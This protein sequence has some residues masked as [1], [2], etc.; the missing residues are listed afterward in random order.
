VEPVHR[1]LVVQYWL[2]RPGKKNWVEIGLSTNKPKDGKISWRGPPVSSLTTRWFRDGK[3][4]KDVAFGFDY[5]DLSIEKILRQTISLHI[6]SILKTTR[7]AVPPRLKMHTSLSKTEPSECFLQVSLGRPD[8]KTT[9]SVEPISGRY[10]LRPSTRVSAQAERAINQFGATTPGTAITQLLTQTMHD[11]IKRCA[12]LLGWRA[13]PRN[14]FRTDVVKQATRMDVLHLVILRPTGWSTKWVLAAVIDASGESWWC[15]ELGGQG[16]VIEHAERIVMEK[17]GSVMEI[18][19]ETLASLGR[20]AIQQLGY[21]VSKKELRKRGIQC[22]LRTDLSTADPSGISSPTVRSV[23]SVAL[24]GWSLEVRTLDLLRSKAGESQWLDPC[25]RVVSQGFGS[26]YQGVS[27][28]AYGMM[29]KSVATDMQRLMSASAQS[30]FVF[31]EDGKFAIHLTTPFGEPIADELTARLRDVDR[32]RSFATILQKRK[33]RLMKSSLQC[34][35]FQYGEK[36]TATVDFEREDE[37]KVSFPPENPHNRIIRL[38]TELVNSH[39]PFNPSRPEESGLDRFCEALVLTRPLLST[40]EELEKATPG[41]LH[42][43]AVFIRHMHS[44][45]VTYANPLCSFDIQLRAR[46]DKRLWHIEDNDKK[47]GDLQPERE[48]KANLERPESLKSALS[49]LFRRPAGPEH[50]WFGVRSGIVAEVDGITNALR[51]LHQAVTSCAS[52]GGH[53]PMQGVKS[54]QASTTAQKGRA[55]MAPSTPVPAAGQVLGNSVQ[56]QAAAQRRNFPNVG[57]QPQGATQEVIEL[58]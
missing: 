21:H 41:N 34:V 56:N 53:N 33:M 38:L 5:D 25:I 35:Q 28:I 48:R 23:S 15:F 22:S 31:Y 51:A 44:Y 29:V 11:S 47:G 19:R 12:E 2:E 46:E 6:S 42:N 17:T 37:I 9:F 20:V 13:L 58:D 40:M 55:A 14:A 18:N 49:T 50:K 36:E 4:V 30:N 3:E 52:E 16:T 54:E 10:F 8:N 27:H 57:R 24:R 45:H 43:P 32:L 39:P 7:D 26:D 1:S